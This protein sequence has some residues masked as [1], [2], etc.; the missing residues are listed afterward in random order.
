MN[1]DKVLKKQHKPIRKKLVFLAGFMG[2]GKT[3]IGKILANTLG[4]EFLD[5]DQIIEERSGKS[6]VTFFREEGEKKFRELERIVLEE[7]VLK[8]EYVVSLGGGTLA[9]EENLDLL[10]KHGVI[11]YLH[12][13]PEVLFQRVRNKTTRP[14]LLDSEGNKISPSELQQRIEKLLKTRKR[15]YEQS[16]III[17]TET[18][19]LGITVDEIVKLLRGKI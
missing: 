19:R 5:V 2:S 13:S 15:Y 11:I 10:R 12:A 17:S 3:T 14:L 8:K 4:F 7:V 9:N 18:Q 1:S 16:H 6:V